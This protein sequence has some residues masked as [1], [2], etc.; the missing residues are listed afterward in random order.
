M[1]Y[2][3]KPFGSGLSEERFLA[4]Q[5]EIHNAGFEFRTQFT[6]SDLGKRFI[7]SC[8]YEEP[9]RPYMS[10]ICNHEYVTGTLELPRK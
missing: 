5:P 3:R 2:G 4:L 6:L 1:I 9:L 10:A 7:E 8:L